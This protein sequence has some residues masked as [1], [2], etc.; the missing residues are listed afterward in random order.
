VLAPHKLAIVGCTALEATV[1]RH[2]EDMVTFNLVFRCLERV[3]LEFLVRFWLMGRACLMLHIHG[4][5][6][7]RTVNG[8]ICR[9]GLDVQVGQ[10]GPVHQ[11]L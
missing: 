11:L 2:I 6:A 4:C 5:M 7:V 9:E 1:L 10:E 8:G 3:G